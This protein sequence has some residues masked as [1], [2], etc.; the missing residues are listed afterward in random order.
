MLTK[1]MKTKCGHSYCSDCINQ[2]LSG[3]R[4]PSSC[5][6]C[7]TNITKRSLDCDKK[8]EAYVTSVRNIIN[9]IKLDCGLE[10]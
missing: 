10:G 3:S 1:P 8:V 6:L 2:L 7:Q 4:G 9:S 5:P